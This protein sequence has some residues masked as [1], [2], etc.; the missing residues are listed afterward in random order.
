MNV[1]CKQNKWSI[2]VVSAPSHRCTLA[3]LGLRRMHLSFH[4]TIPFPSQRISIDATNDAVPT[5]DAIS[6]ATASL[7]RLRTVLF[8]LRARQRGEDSR[9]RNSI[10]NALQTHILCS[11]KHHK[12]LCPSME[13]GRTESVAHSQLLV[14]KKPYTIP[15]SRTISQTAHPNAQTLNAILSF[16]RIS[17]SWSA[18]IF[19]CFFPT[20]DND[21]D[22]SHAFLSGEWFWWQF[23]ELN[24]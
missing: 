5:V 15:D 2:H 21:D 17:L 18:L 22:K 4:H 16:H 8:P 7:Q 11:R 1:K 20:T 13:W 10:Q 12:P 19:G 9:R 6:C 23:R 3:S 14:Y 24:I